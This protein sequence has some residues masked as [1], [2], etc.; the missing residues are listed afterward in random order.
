[1]STEINRPD[2]LAAPLIIREVRAG[3]DAA[4]EQ[5]LGGLDATSRYRRWFTAGVDIRQAERWASHPE[6]VGAVGLLA[7]AGVEPVGHAVLVP[8]ATRRAE[9]AF[10]VAA[11]WRRH[12][13]AGAL[14]KRL[15]EVAAERGLREVYAAVLPENADMLA[16][17][18][19]HGEHTESRDG[20]VAIVTIAAPAAPPAVAPA[21]V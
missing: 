1:M 10:E 11:P 8:C 3:D 12:G 13:I 16:V 6:R 20:G 9:V 15:L 18:R 5:L 14:L 19:E 2:P 21:A 7:F 17:L 4:I